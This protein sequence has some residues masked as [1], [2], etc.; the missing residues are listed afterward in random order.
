MSSQSVPSLTQAGSGH[1]RCPLQEEDEK[2]KGVRMRDGR[3][4]IVR[5]SISRR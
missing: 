2:D 4:A 5:L 1:S 3:R